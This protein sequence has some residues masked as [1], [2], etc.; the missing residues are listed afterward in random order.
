MTNQSLNNNVTIKDIAL[1]LEN[2]GVYLKGC[3]EKEVKKIESYYNIKLPDTYIDFLMIMG[4]SAGKFMLGSSAFYN[5]IFSLK[6][7]ANDLLEENDMNPLSEDVFVFWV[8][9][10]YQFTF[11]DLKDGGNPPFYWYCE[12][13]HKHGFEKKGDSFTQ[14]LE[15]Q[16][17]DSG[18]RIV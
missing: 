5:D 4:K 3:S 10:G 17:I 7:E 14:F 6:D 18:F 8:H 12:G 1:E 15:M 2:Q 16:L 11:F 13:I 9:Q